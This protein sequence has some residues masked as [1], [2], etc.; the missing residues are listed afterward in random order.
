MC[1]FTYNDQCKKLSNGFCKRTFRWNMS[2]IIPPTWN[3]SSGYLLQKIDRITKASDNFWN[4]RDKNSEDYNYS[5]YEAWKVCNGVIEFPYI[6][7]YGYDDCWLTAT[8]DGDLFRLERISFDDWMFLEYIKR[9]GTKGIHIQTGNVYW[10]SSTQ[11]D[12]IR[13]IESELH[14]GQITSANELIAAKT[15]TFQ[16]QLGSPLTH[17]M[18]SEWNLE[19]EINFFHE[20]RKCIAGK[21]I[22]FSRL[23]QWIDEHNQPIFG[24]IIKEF[25]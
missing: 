17:S 21:K 8:S 4:D 11:V 23:E 24:R 9:Y 14:F 19:D 16:D 15:I 3:T 10:I 13:C 2:N 18:Q 5:Y 20:I 6:T 22:R 7:D 12:L 1:C 25:S